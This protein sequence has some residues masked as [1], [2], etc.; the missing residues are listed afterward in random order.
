MTGAGRLIALSLAT[1]GI[2]EGM[3]I[4]FLPIYLQELGAGPVQIGTVFGLAGALMALVHLPAGV[5]SDRF[6]PK[7]VMAAGWIQ[8][9]LATWLMYAARSLPLFTAGLLV[10]MMTFYI[11]SPMA[12]Y[13][14]AARGRWSTARA[15]TT[16]SAAYNLG[17][18]A[19]PL[20]G[21]Q[22][23]EAIGLRSIFAIAGT[24]FV[25][26]TTLILLLPRQEPLRN[27]G[28]GDGREALRR[29]ATLGFLGLVMLGAFAMY[30]SWPLTPNYLQEV[31]GVTLAQ[32]GVFGSL[33]A[34]GIVA[35]NLSLGRLEARRGFLMAQA[36]V[37]LSVALL[38][39]GGGPAGFG[40]GYLLAG[41]FR[42]FRAFVTAMI[43]LQVEASGRGRAYGV[44]ETVQGV[45]L[46]L[47]PPLAGVLYRSDP[48]LPYPVA[49]VLIACAFL[50]SAR[51]APRTRAEPALQGSAPR[52]ETP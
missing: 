19:G 25:V 7:G 30:L 46:L 18:A 3:F 10:Y 35:L 21:G 37:G 26:S 41:G 13:L 44:V 49:L 16:V 31:H 32:I 36:A 38:W 11:M 1:W 8:A 39:R 48:A 43:E 33:N 45:A 20:I 51:F 9:L 42:T 4:Y 12:S 28:P 6:G 34:L 14:T 17:A 23:G 40:L 2:G 47:A 5:L 15:L 27:P 22:V 52:R 24:L 29:P 50:L